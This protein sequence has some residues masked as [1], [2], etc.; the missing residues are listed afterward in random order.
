[1][2]WNKTAL[3]WKIVLKYEIIYLEYWAS[4]RNRFRVVEM[5]MGSWYAWWL[6]VAHQIL[7][8]Y[9]L[10]KHEP[11]SWIPRRHDIWTT[12]P[13]FYYWWLK[14]FGNYNH[15]IHKMWFCDQMKDVKVRL[16]QDVRW[17]VTNVIVHSLIFPS[18]TAKLFKI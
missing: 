16:I 18:I 12:G 1:M 14:D 8:R 10:L 7:H 6:C 13:F 5:N 15:T 4:N 3:G 17:W 11:T 2:I 9:D